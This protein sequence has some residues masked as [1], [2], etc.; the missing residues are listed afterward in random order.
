MSRH[1]ILL[2]DAHE[3]PAYE[4]IEALRNA[5]VKTLIEGL[6]EVEVEVALTRQREGEQ[7]TPTIGPPPLAVLYEVVPGADMVELHTA[8]EHAKAFWP[9]APLIACRRH[10]N[11]YQSLNLRSLDGTTLKRLGFKA[12]ADKAAQLPAILREIEGQGGTGELKLPP[13]LQPP[14]DPTTQL[15]PANLKSKSLRAAFDLVSSLHF[16][17]DQIGAAHA[18]L[19]GL[20]PL[21]SADRWTI[22]LASDSSSGEAN[23]LEAIAVRRRGDQ[24]G[25]MVEDD[26]RR[27]LAGE[28]AVPRG[29]ETK[30]AKLAAAG[31]GLVRKK[32]RG[33]YVVALP[34]I[35]GER[36][37]GVLEGIRDPSGARSFKKSE[38]ALLESLSLPIASA[39]ANAVRI[40]E[41]E[42]LSQTDDLTKLHNARYLRQFLLNEIRRARRYGSSVAALFLDLD[43]FKAINDVH[44]HLVGSHVLM[45]IAA[46]ILSSVRD[47]DAVARYGGDE[48][49]IVLPDTGIELAAVVAERIREKIR[50]FQFTG[51]RRLCLTLTAS[52]G[53]AAFPLHASS[54]QQL[55]ACADTAMYEAKAANKNC[56]RIS[57]GPLQ[58]P[59][60]DPADRANFQPN[61]PDQKSSSRQQNSG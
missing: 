55:I 53:V 17:S 46:V 57:T 30:A 56:V 37:L 35:C 39:L 58:N 7:A 18:A 8:I 2:T 34:L 51:G 38:V 48:Y 12:I 26:W 50:R 27:L 32:E 4:L 6:R 42:R 28:A 15:L 19:T 60:V 22:Y 13:N 9:G 5:G 33:Q 61:K 1:V 45:E 52:F 3:A 31:V 47:T 23:A 29:S 20:E 21:L 49:V 25:S 41:A 10:A 43:D 59:K 44:G 40:A 11:G 14:P 54:P 24:F 16:I 36:L